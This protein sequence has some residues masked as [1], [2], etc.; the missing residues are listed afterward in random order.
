HR[1]RE[2]YPQLVL[3]LPVIPVFSGRATSPHCFRQSCQILL[4]IL[5]SQKPDN[6]SHI[7]GRAPAKEKSTIGAQSVAA[8]LLVH[9]AENRKKIAQD[10]HAALRGFYALRN[11]HD[12]VASVINGGE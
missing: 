6:G 8:F 2:G 4:V 9:E 1:P 10:T 11:L 7:R 3:R 12:L 5:V